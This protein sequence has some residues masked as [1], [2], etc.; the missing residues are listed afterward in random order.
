[1]KH[2]EVGDTLVILAERKNQFDS[3]GKY[4]Q[5]D[6]YVLPALHVIGH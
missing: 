6:F 4:L 3:F 2:K 1:M 5:A